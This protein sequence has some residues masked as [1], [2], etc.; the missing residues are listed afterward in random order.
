MCLQT[1]CCQGDDER[2]QPRAGGRDTTHNTRT[3]TWED[4]RITAMQESLFQQ[5]SSV[6]TLF[7][8]G[9]QTLLS[10]TISSPTPTTNGKL[11]HNTSPTNSVSDRV[12][13][14]TPVSS[15]SKQE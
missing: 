1:V 2:L 15:F 6:E 9:S 12:H 10:P 3:T 7:N 5:Q 11:W 14:N 8:T 13:S 4:P